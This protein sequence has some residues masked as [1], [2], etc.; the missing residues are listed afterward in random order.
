MLKIELENRV[1]NKIYIGNL[2]DNFI[3]EDYDKLIVNLNIQECLEQLIIHAV[4]TPN[5]N[6]LYGMDR[7]DYYKFYFIIFKNLGYLTA[8]QISE[9]SIVFFPINWNKI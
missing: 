1:K 5:E 6:F 3:P 9:N 8:Y 4:K 2:I 7:F